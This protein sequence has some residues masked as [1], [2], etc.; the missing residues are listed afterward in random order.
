M[1]ETITVIGII[2]VGCAVH[3]WLLRAPRSSLPPVDMTITRLTRDEFR[4]D[5]DGA[6]NASA[7]GP[8]EVMN[9]AGKRVMYFSRPG[10]QVDDDRE[11][12]ARRYGPA[13]P[14]SRPQL[15]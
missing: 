8:V 7:H 3:L 5:P 9:D 13:I 6:I 1:F 11:L 15:R 14:M 2:A 10:S 4:A 12:M